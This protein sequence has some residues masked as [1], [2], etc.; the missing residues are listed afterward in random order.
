MDG[1]IVAVAV[2]DAG[3]MWWAFCEARAGI[4]RNTLTQTADQLDIGL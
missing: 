4:R 3:T 2:L 1:A